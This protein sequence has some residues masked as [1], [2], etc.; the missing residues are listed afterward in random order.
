M[1]PGLDLRLIRADDYSN[2]NKNEAEFD[3]EI[4]HTSGC[5]KSTL[6]DDG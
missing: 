3:A 2:D 1:T 5:Q 4:N 6:S